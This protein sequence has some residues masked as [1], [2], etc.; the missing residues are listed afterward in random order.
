MPGQGFITYY[1]PLRNSDKSNC[2]I[3]RAKALKDSA[4]TLLPN[5]I[6][7]SSKVLNLAYVR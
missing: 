6:I 3:L 7:L 4:L 2:L 5:N 1:I